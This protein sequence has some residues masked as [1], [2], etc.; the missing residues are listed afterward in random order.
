MI[1]LLEDDLELKVREEEVD[2]VDPS[3]RI[4]DKMGIIKQRIF[5]GWLINLGL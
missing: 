3:V 4:P 5:F 1:K 2:I